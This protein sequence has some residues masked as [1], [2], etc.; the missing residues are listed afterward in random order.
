MRRALVDWRRDLHRHPEL[1]FEEKRTA[2]LG[3]QVLGDLGLE[4][5]AGT[6]RPGSRGSFR[7]IA[8]IL[9]STRGRFP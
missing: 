3:A 2:A 9:T 7:I 8:S 4:V 5:R 1:A 6:G